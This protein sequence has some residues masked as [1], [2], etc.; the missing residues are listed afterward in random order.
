MDRWL[1]DVTA[2]RRIALDTNLVIYHLEGR[3]IYNALAQH[4]LYLMERGLVVAL[5]ST[6]VVAEV[7]VKPL[8]EQN[9]VILD[10]AELFFRESPNLVVRNFDRSIANRAA[11]VRAATRLSLADAVIVATALEERCDELIGND[12][13][14]ARRTTEIPY[15]YME[16]YIA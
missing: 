15:L 3:A 2:Y 10:R 7:L 6:V 13:A 11:Q 12:A 1:E 16:D 14:M 4:L 8:R 9:R 5:V